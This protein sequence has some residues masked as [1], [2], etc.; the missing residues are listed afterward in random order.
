[1]ILVS[2]TLLENPMNTSRFQLGLIS[3]LA[4]A[5]GFSMASSL[6]IGYPA[7]A[8][9]SLGSNPVVS[10]GGRLEGTDR[11]TPLAVPSDSS[12]VIT[13][14]VLSAYSEEVYCMANSSIVIDDGTHT[15]AEFVVGLGRSSSS[16]SGYEPTLVVDLSSGIHIPA[17]ATLAISSQINL[18]TECGAHPLKVEYTLSGYYAQP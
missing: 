1:M 3:T 11:H 13:G 8:A 17:G 14:V 2:I 15:L 18:Q 9:V 7:G 16:Y 10:R 12:L 5:L 6:A 4:L